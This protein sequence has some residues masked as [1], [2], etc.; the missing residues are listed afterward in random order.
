MI[1]NLTTLA[2]LWIGASL[3]LVP[4]MIAA[5]RLAVL[6]LIEAI[7]RPRGAAVAETRLARLEEEAELALPAPPFP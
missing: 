2:T 6:P 1:P 3:L 4:L 7:A 5:V